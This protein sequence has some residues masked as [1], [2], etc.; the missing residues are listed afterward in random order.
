MSPLAYQNL[1]AEMDP[2][3]D[4]GAELVKEVDGSVDEDGIGA[5][6]EYGGCGVILI[7]PPLAGNG[8]GSVVAKEFAVGWHKSAVI[9]VPP[10]RVK[11]RVARA[12]PI[13]C[14]L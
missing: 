10:H 7:G 3:F 8:G 1:T 4:V 11:E 12:R 9:T 5:S 13:I 14:M 2:A 6:D